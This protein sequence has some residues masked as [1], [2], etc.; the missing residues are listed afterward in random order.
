[1][2]SM[3]KPLPGVSPKGKIIQQ[4]MDLL[5]HKRQAPWQR[6]LANYLAPSGNLRSI[7]I[8]DGFER[9]ANKLADQL[10]ALAGTHIAIS[11]SVV[12]SGMMLC[13]SDEKEEFSLV[14]HIYVQKP[15]GIVAGAFIGGDVYVAPEYRGRGLGAELMLA[16]AVIDD[17][18]H[19]D[20]LL[21]TR[22]GL[23]AALASH[24]LA[25]QLAVQ[26]GDLPAVDETVYAE[27]A[28]RLLGPAAPRP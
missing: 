25:A 28:E 16:R 24:R 13:I 22:S 20:G 26:W 27:M 21:Y 14:R 11:S 8:D 18:G 7:E 12:A 15:N 9:T 19:R 23:A 6:S 2:L 17:Q 5:R 1:M 3:T 4:G 10:P